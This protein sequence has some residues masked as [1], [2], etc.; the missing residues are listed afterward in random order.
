LIFGNLNGKILP[1]NIQKK[2]K[3]NFI[4]QKSWKRT[5]PLWAAPLA[6]LLLL[7]GCFAAAGMFPFGSRTLAW[8]DMNH[9]S[10]PL[11]MDFKDILA[12]KASIFLNLQNAGGTNFWGI[13]FFFLSSPFSFLTAFVPK[14]DFYLFV[15]LLVLLKLA[16]AACTASIL[17]LRVFPHLNPVQVSCFA[18][19]YACSG[20]SLM[21]YQNV[22]WLDIAYLFPLLMLGI[23]MLSREEKPALFFII[24]SAMITVNYYLSAMMLFWLVLFFAVLCA[25]MTNVHRC[26]RMLVL[27]GLSTAAAFLLTAVIWVPSFLQYLSSGRGVNL[28]SS[29]SSGSFFTDFPTTLPILYCTGAAVAAIPLYL[30]AEKKSSAGKVLFVTFLFLLVPLLIDPIDRMWHL[31]SYQ[32]FPVRFGYIIAMT[33]LLLAGEHL[34]VSQRLSV[35]HQASS[36]LLL[37]LACAGVAAVP[38]CGAYLLKAKRQEITNYTQSLWGSQDSMM[39]ELLVAAA[40][41]CIYLL[42]FV[43]YRCRKLSRGMLCL[44]LCAL[45]T[46]ELCFHVGIYVTSAA[47]D[48]HAYDAV[49]N[50]EGKVKDPSLYRMKTDGLYFDTNLVGALGYPAMD[51]YTS[52]NGGTY[53]DTMQK[54]G[55]SARWMESRSS[56]GTLLTD[57]ML[58]QKYSI[59]RT[60]EENG[61]KLIYGNSEYSIVQQPEVLPFGFVTQQLGSKLTD[62][63]RFAAQD[64]LY[65]TLLGGSGN[66]MTHYQPIEYDRTQ[67]QKRGKTY[68]ITAQTGG[69][70]FY[71]FLVTEKTNLYFDCYTKASRDLST[72]NDDSFR[73]YVNDVLKSDNYPDGKFNG[74]LD[75]GAYEDEEVNI[76]VEV[77]HDTDCCSFGVAG[78][79]VGRLQQALSHTETANIHASSSTLSGTVAAAKGGWLMLPMC[80][81]NGFQ[82]VVNGQPAEIGTAAGMFLAVKLQQGQNRVSITYIPQGF[83]AGAI[84]SIIG[85]AVAV[86]ILLMHKKKWL[87]RLGWLERPANFL[88]TVIA[89]VFTILLYIYPVAVYL[90]GSIATQI[91]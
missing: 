76:R 81:G 80:G 70:F 75:L 66:L 59:T 78:L 15:N 91:P 28:G 19:M 87:D 16:L 29:L 68:H 90:A 32:A 57:A 45:T 48:G 47:N 39:W 9:Q 8:C 77:L 36:P 33:G 1:Y 83:T 58:A 5:S 38:L 73:I 6:V 22:V 41:I 88:F 71:K 61:R 44:L 72:P 54:I 64:T 17:F 11:L 49:L 34:D 12:G 23:W 46:S 65:R 30:L 60:G 26:G 86:L 21:Y 35:P 62:G 4:V 85:V 51:H 79:P 42:L 31:G 2:E 43:G 53:M 10:I 89:A 13:F 14:A 20:F 63:D 74:I 3:R 55:Y 82:A 27:L 18:A 56:G 50:L 37:V 67:V 84:C 52:L 24:L 69:S 25:V 40:V 7:C